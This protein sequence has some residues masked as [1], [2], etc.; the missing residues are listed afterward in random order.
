MTGSISDIVSRLRAVLPKRWFAEQAPNLAAILQSIAAP[1]AWLYSLDL[2]AYDFFG[3]KLNRKLSESDLNYRSRIKAAL[4]REAAT[5]T[6][7]SAGLEALIGSKPTLFEPANCMDTGSYGTLIAG[8]SI[9]GTGLAYGSAGGWGSLV[10]PLQFFVTASRPATPGISML[11]GYGTPN[12]AYGEGQISYINLDL[13]PG[14]VTDQDIQST[15]CGLLP[16]NAVAWLRI[17]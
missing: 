16:V 9:V 1:W 4:L 3:T 10:L 12:G 7:V 5:R 14:H 17:Q 2:I 15:L 6:A 8:S 11:A 13:L